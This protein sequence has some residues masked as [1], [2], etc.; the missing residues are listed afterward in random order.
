MASEFS[1][2][3]DSIEA[4]PQMATAGPSGTFVFHGVSDANKETVEK[5]HFFFYYIF[6]LVCFKFIVFITRLEFFSLYFTES[7][8]FFSSFVFQN[9]QNVA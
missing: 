2:L 4:Y 1:L 6:L 3:A 7:S 5:V 9:F 8:F